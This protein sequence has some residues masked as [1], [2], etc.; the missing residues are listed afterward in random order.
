MGDYFVS[1]GCVRFSG[2]TVIQSVL[3]VSTMV[4]FPF[5]LFSDR[6]VR[7]TE[8]AIEELAGDSTPHWPCL[9]PWTSLPGTVYLKS[10][11]CGW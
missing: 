11:G 5:F 2:G 4:T 10:W 9:S 8:S 1:S 6:N 7:D 3:H